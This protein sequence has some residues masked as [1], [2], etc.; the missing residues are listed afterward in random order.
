MVVSKKQTIKETDDDDDTEDPIKFSTTKAYNMS[1]NEYRVDTEDDP[2]YQPFCVMFGFAAMLI[3]FCILREE[4]DIDLILNSD[5]EETLNRVQRE[6]LE[7]ERIK[8]GNTVHS[9]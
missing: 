5:L 7:N 9:K 4:N 1:Y 2:W 8:L 3:Y 6:K